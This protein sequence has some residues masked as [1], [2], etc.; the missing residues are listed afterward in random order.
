MAQLPVKGGVLPRSFR[1][2]PSREVDRVL[3]PT[4]AALVLVV[5]EGYLGLLSLSE[6]GLEC[7]LVEEGLS[8]LVSLLGG[9]DVGGSELVF[10]A[11]GSQAGELALARL[12]GAEVAGS[13][14]VE[15]GGPGLEGKRLELVGGAETLVPDGDLLLLVEVEH[16]LANVEAALGALQDL[17][18]EHPLLADLLAGGPHNM[19]AELAALLDGL[20][21]QGH[22]DSEA[23]LVVLDEGGVD[24]G[25]EVYE[26]VEQGHHLLLLNAADQHVLLEDGEEHA[27]G[28]A[29]LHEGE[30]VGLQLGAL[31]LLQ[32]ILGEYAG[33][34][35]ALEVELGE[36]DGL[37]IGREVARLLEQVDHVREHALLVLVDQG[38]VLLQHALL[39]LHRDASPRPPRVLLVHLELARAVA[40]QGEQLDVCIEAEALEVAEGGDLVLEDDLAHGIDVKEFAGAR[41]EELV[42]VEAVEALVPL[43]GVLE[44]VAPKE[45]AAPQG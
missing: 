25:V 2:Q 10:D 30:A 24:H 15:F 17:Q 20:G 18:R 5:E 43:V 27:G 8:L 9:G 26:G 35:H 34:E 28:L 36:N 3:L 19:G 11:G 44:R 31:Q 41:R 22:M 6:H 45:A 13:A 4:L 7:V 33:V 1:F 39:P 29:P 38:Q 21:A 16:A 32:L 40:G 12:V 14:A 42:H 23:V 37:D